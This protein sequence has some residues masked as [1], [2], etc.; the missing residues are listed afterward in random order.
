[1]RSRS[2]FRRLTRRCGHIDSKQIESRA[3]LPRCAIAP[4]RV[5]ERRISAREQRY[6]ALISNFQLYD[7][8]SA[9]VA[10]ANQTVPSIALN[11]RAVSN[12]PNTPL[13]AHLDKGGASLN[14]EVRAAIA[15][16][17][18]RCTAKRVTSPRP[19]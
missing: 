16:Y 9:P 5:S 15:P 14:S 10:R 3:R 18:G 8:K 6:V 7:L 2:V 19:S 12:H 17:M 11:K 4:R 1:A 13:V